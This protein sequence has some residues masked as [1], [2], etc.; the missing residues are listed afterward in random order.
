MSKIRFVSDGPQQPIRAYDE[1]GKEIEGVESVLIEK[2]EGE[3]TR[4]V[5]AFKNPVFDVV[6]EDVSGLVPDDISPQVGVIF[7]NPGTKTKQ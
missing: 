2:N 5:M 7:S 6:A 1:S 3:E 4:A